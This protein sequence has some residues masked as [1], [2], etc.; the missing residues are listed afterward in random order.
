MT[1]TPAIDIDALV[2]IDI[3]VHAGVSARNPPAE[4]TAQARD[5]TLARE[6]AR[7][8]AQG[9]TPAETAAYYRER[10]IACA[11]WGGDPQS[12]NSWRKGG[13]S[14]DEMLEAAEANNDILIPF[15]MVDPWRGEAGAR[16]AQRLIDM[17]ARGFKFHPLTQAFFANERRFYELYQVLAAN[18]VPALFHT[19]QTAVGQ[20][21]PGG[22]GVHL[23]YGNPRRGQAVAAE[24]ERGSTA[25]P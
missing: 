8:G 11:I 17:G 5:D 18:K 2:A 20:G 13:V 3:H 16:E 7:S 4:R 19:G 23:K 6:R 9:Q 12:T 1:Y 14:N 22:G 21:A 15:V 24:G 25:G 10:K